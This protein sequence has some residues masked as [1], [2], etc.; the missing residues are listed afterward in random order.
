MAI[1][2]STPISFEASQNGD[3]QEVYDQ[4]IAEVGDYS[5]LI[6]PHC[7]TRGTL[8]PCGV[9][10]RYF[11][12]S[13][14]DHHSGYLLTITVV[15]CHGAKCGHEHALFPS[16]IC[17]YSHFSYPFILAILNFLHSGYLLTIT[18]V[19]CHGAKCGHEHALFPSWI[20]PYSHFSYPFILA[21]LNFLFN[22]ADHN[23]SKTA[24][25]FNIG[26]AEVRNLA[27]KYEEEQNQ[28]R[29]ISHVKS[30]RLSFSELL[31]LLKQK[32]DELR[33][34]LDEFI[35][36]HAQPFLLRHIGL[37]RTKRKMTIGQFISQKDNCDIP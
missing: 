8:R 27:S 28:V 2:I 23:L 22:E 12:N 11:Y 34:F 19:K 3:W 15:K 31:K 10:T 26:R 9:Y 13:P 35:L 17:P 32:A 4:A 37:P 30:R 36:L 7:H 1:N 6:C 29:E 16:W 18:V 5:Q 33:A 14:E 21:I 24:R 25:T 20:C